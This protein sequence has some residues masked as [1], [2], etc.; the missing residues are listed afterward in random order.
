MGYHLG[1]CIQSESVKH[2]YNQSVEDELLHNSGWTEDGY[3]LFAISTF[4]GSSAKGYFHPIPE[5]NAL[6]MTRD[7]WDELGGFDTQFNSPGGGLVN[8]DTY[9]RACNLQDAR[10][11]LILGEGTFHQIHG[12]VSSNSKADPWETFHDEYVA[13]RGKAFARP[14]TP[15]YFVGNIRGHDIKFIHESANMALNG[16]KVRRSDLFSNSVKYYFNKLITNKRPQQRSQS[17]AK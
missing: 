4:A 12:G 14:E 8:L 5:S 16:K 17:A 1:P 7:M 9:Y 10:P 11:I 2:G 6:F 15:P 3:Q 13:I